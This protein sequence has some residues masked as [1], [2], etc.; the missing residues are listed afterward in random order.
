MPR[1]ALT[2]EQRR[3]TRRVI[4]RAAAELYARDGPSSISARRIAETAGVSVGTLYSYFDNLTE[5]MQSLW[6]EPVWRLINE[7]EAALADI[8]D[9]L[10]KLR[11]LLETYARF[12]R[13]QRAVYR[14]AFLFVRPASEQQPDRVA[15]DDDRFFRLLRGTVLAAQQR[16]VARTGDPDMLAQ[17]V[18]SGVHGAIA[19]PQNMDRL[20]LAPPEE[21][22]QPMIEAMLEWLATGAAP[23]T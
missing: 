3:Q 23:Q 6:K 5:L 9:P 19:L 10:E 12:S 13:E 22:V 11:T 4:R 2:D 1:P 17:T 14:G 8:D 18:W 7:L 21:A 15:L 20:A 16:G